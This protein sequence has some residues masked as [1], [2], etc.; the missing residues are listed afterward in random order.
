MSLRQITI[1][2]IVL[3]MVMSAGCVD[4]LTD[5]EILTEASWLGRVADVNG[6]GIANATVTLHVLGPGGEIYSRQARSA[7][8]EPVRGIYSFEH[9]ELR[10]GADRAYT[11]CNVTQG[12][13][14]LSGEGE[15]RP[16]ADGSRASTITVNGKNIT[17]ITYG[18]VVD[19]RLIL[20]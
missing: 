6:S 12:G 1:A 20:H 15:V 18:G 4:L 9:I 11:T 14:T 13:R 5:Q 8:S 17:A 10:G 19:E 3:G 7:S 16:L 2:L